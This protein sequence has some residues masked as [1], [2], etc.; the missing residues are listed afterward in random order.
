MATAEIIKPVASK[1]MRIIG[2]NDMGKYGDS[3][4][5]MAL[6]VGPNGKRTL[7][8]AHLNAPGDFSAIDVSDPRN[9]TVIYSQE[10]PHM[11]M[12]SNCLMIVGNTMLVCRQ[13]N[14][15]GDK[16]AGVEVF[17][18]ANPAQPKSIGFWDASGPESP[19]AHYV[20]FID[21]RYAYV[22]SGTSDW[23][24]HGPTMGWIVVI[25]DLQDPTKPREVGRWHLPGTSKKD[26]FMVKS[27]AEEWAEAMGIQPPA[28]NEPGP[29]RGAI[30]VGSKM[31]FNSQNR[32]HDI[33]VYPQRPDRA[34]VAYLDSG[35]VILDITDKANPKMVTQFDYHPPF[36]GYTHTVMPIFSKELLAITEEGSDRPLQDDQP[37]TLRFADMSYE[38]KLELVSQI[39]LP[40][41]DKLKGKERFGAHNLY[42]NTPVPGSFAS[43][44]VVV[45]TFFSLGVRVYDIADP[46]RPELTAYCIPP[47][48]KG[49]PATQINDLHIDERGIIYVNERSANGLYVMEWDQ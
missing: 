29:R 20:W 22:A 38:P 44:D 16:P 10:L 31:T 35:A 1:N 14:H 7:F 21:G 13:V 34:Y 12:R 6:H 39:T 24:P 25:L 19:G 8:M 43:E 33:Y 2:H 28:W 5:G 36:P 48:P 15:P 47:A 41:M 9:P 11:N 4:E 49:R 30:E 37:K 26:G 42:D 45:G 17:D 23:D 27:H 46:F 3:G 40:D 32:V 18:V